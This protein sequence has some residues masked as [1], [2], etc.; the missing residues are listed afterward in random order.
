MDQSSSVVA[1]RGPTACAFAVTARTRAGARE[2][3]TGCGCCGARFAVAPYHATPHD[4]KFATA[5][6]R[7]FVQRA[8]E[9]PGCGD[10]RRPG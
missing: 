8:A 1:A 7:A 2:R 6:F 5:A 10:L 9:R 4:G 3:G